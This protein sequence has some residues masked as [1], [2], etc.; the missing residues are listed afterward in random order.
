MGKKSKEDYITPQE[1]EAAIQATSIIKEIIETKKE[2]RSILNGKSD[3]QLREII[4]EYEDHHTIDGTL[5]SPETYELLKS[6]FLRRNHCSL[7]NPQNK[8][9][10]MLDSKGE[11]YE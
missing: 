11:N 3:D 2:L 6:E 1:F 9:N 8:I 10:Q 5:A 7:L 4:K